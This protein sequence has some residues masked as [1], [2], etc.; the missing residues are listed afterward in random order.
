MKIKGNRRESRKLIE[1]MVRLI[2]L[3]MVNRIFDQENVMEDFN[4]Y[5]SWSKKKTL[6]ELDGWI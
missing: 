5:F 4:L 6:E 2:I 1:S 3:F